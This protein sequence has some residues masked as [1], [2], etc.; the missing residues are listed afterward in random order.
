MKTERF[1]EQ[2]VLR[3]RCGAI[4]LR[5]GRFTC[6]YR[7]IHASARSAK[8]MQARNVFCLRLC[9]RPVLVGLPLSSSQ[10]HVC[11]LLKTSASRSSPTPSNSCRSACRRPLSAATMSRERGGMTTGPA[12]P[13]NTQI[14][15]DLKPICFDRP[16]DR[17][18][19]RQ[20]PCAAECP[21][22][23]SAHREP[24]AVEAALVER[25][26]L[27]ERSIA[28][29]GFQRC[30]ARLLGHAVSLQIP[31]HLDPLLRLRGI[32]GD[33]ERRV[34]LGGAASSAKRARREPADERYRRRARRRHGGTGRA[35]TS[36]SHRSPP[37][38]IEVDWLQQPVLEHLSSSAP[39]NS[40]A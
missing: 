15:V 40:R 3:T 25:E 34:T 10:S 14:G 9:V 6:Y 23:R 1:T 30:F 19:R 28:S 4:D 39:L 38:C 24:H 21:M 13:W 36:P 8:E 20:H 17:N 35:G 7:M 5:E 12:L 26:F 32:A 2:Q 18:R 37:A 33:D 11:R 22:C 29:N 31:R 27:L 16:R